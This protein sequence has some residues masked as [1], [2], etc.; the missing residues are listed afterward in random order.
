MTCGEHAKIMAAL[1]PPGQMGPRTKAIYE[2]FTSQADEECIAHES[3]VVLL[4]MNAV[5]ED[6]EGADG[7]WSRA[8][9]GFEEKK[10]TEQG[11]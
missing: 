6:N 2:R 8:L 5:K 9:E 1:I 11:T 10:S 7:S 3:Q 4:F